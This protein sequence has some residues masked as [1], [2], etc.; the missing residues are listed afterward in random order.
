MLG[1]HVTRLY[2]DCIEMRTVGNMRKHRHTK[3]YENEKHKLH[4]E[5]FP[6]LVKKMRRAAKS[7]NKQIKK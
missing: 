6:I 7:E 2:N 4:W 1:C 3:Y 5:N